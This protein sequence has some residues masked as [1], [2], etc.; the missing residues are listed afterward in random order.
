MKEMGDSKGL[1]SRYSFML[2]DL[3]IRKE[4]ILPTTLKRDCSERA[5]DEENF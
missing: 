2:Q 1:P 5:L 3:S 4:V